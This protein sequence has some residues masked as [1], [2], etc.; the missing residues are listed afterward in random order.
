MKINKRKSKRKFGITEK[1][2][3]LENIINR[4]KKKKKKRI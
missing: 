1:K 3:E 4:K 2:K